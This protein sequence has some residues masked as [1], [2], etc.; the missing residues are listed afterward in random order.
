MAEFQQKHA[1]YWCLITNRKRSKEAI[2]TACQQR[3][4]A[5]IFYDSFKNDL[6]GDRITDHSLA[7]YEGKMFVLFI[8]LAILTRLKM[9]LMEKRKSSVTVQ[10]NSIKSR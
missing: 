8:A 3:N 1:G 6:N 10:L 4:T 9:K 5:E 2:Y 7:S